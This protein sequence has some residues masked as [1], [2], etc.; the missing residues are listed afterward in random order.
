MLALD[1]NNRGFPTLKLY[2]KLCWVYNN[3]VMQSPLFLKGVYKILG[4]KICIWCNS[5]TGNFLFWPLFFVEIAGM[6]VFSKSQVWNFQTFQSRVCFILH[7][8]QC[9]KFV[10]HYNSDAEF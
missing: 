2:V 8:A 3:K 6:K 9:G 5:V 1:Y 10:L 4:H 7:L